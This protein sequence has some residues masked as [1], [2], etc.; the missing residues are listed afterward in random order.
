[1]YYI[2]IFYLMRPLLTEVF[3][4]FTV[5]VYLINISLTFCLHVFHMMYHPMLN[6]S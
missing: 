5:Y 6:I 1:M 2:G 4:T 3:L